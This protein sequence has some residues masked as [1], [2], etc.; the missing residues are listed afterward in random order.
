MSTNYIDSVSGG[1]VQQGDHNRQT[2]RIGAPKTD[3]DH[4]TE[5]EE[6]LR[7][8]GA[9]RQLRTALSE[10]IGAAEDNGGVLPAAHQEKA[11]KSGLWAKVT[12]VL[13]DV[14]GTALGTALKGMFGL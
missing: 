3:A 5:L 8:A 6:L 11:R 1:Q 2:V 7:V 13:T 10:L 9:P 14:A 12:D 4:L